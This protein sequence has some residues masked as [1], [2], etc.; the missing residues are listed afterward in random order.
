MGH[1]RALISVESADIQLDIFKS[2][3][4]K[5]LSVRQVEELVRNASNA[6][7]KEKKEDK[8]EPSKD[9]V[10]LQTKLTSHFGTKIK[11]ASD[12]NKGEIKIPFVSIEDLNR[13]L[14]ILDID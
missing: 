5:D 2:I 3:V 12:G 11:V 13:I 7:V 6:K 10:Q 14:E 1:A 8:K 9:I 4:E